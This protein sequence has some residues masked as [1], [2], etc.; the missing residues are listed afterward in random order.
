VP[1]EVQ[2]AALEAALR[3][4][5]TLIQGPPGTGKTV[6]ST[7]LVWLLQQATRDKVLMAAPSNVAVDHLA[8]KIAAT[9][10]KARV[11]LPS[12]SA[13]LPV[14]QLHDASFMLSV[15]SASYV[16]QLF[17]LAPGTIPGQTSN[18]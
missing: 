12:V 18:E 1:N 5:F 15:A 10:L 6:T 17:C 13:V 11:V 2:V 3:Q 16:R 9:G 14:L 4:P 8:E 7:T